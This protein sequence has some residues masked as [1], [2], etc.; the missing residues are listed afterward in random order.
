[1][2]ILIKKSNNKPSI[3]TCIRGDG[4]N[5]WT[6]LHQG[7]EI[8]DIAHFVVETELSF[9]DAFYGTVA[10]GININ[11][12]ELPTKQ[13]PKE[14]I[15]TNLSLHALQTEHIVNLLQIHYLNTQNDFNFIETLK[16]IFNKH[17]MKFPPELTEE[18][19]EIIKNH[20]ISLMQQWESL[21]EGEE[22]ELYF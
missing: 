13:R 1:M 14:V 7:L 4:S 17:D 11:D 6:K 3:L 12:Y 15:P 22:L 10:K 21:N 16:D 18:K 5:T 20:L 19:F 2:K 8:H 9:K